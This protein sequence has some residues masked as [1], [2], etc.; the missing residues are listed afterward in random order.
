MQALSAPCSEGL[1]GF[2]DVIFRALALAALVASPARTASRGYWIQP[3]PEDP[4]ETALRDAL[5]L[6]GFSGP[7]E[8]ADALRRVADSRPGTAAAGLARLGAGYALLDAAQPQAALGQLGHP[9][10]AKTALSEY[11]LLA[12]GQAKEALRDAPGAAA[13]YLAAADARPN[14]PLACAALYKAAESF[15]RASELAS[16]VGTLGRALASCPGQEARTLF[17]IA[18]LQEQQNDRKAAAATLDRLDHEYPASPQALAIQRRLASLA[19]LLPAED[20]AARLAHDVRKALALFEANNCAAATPLLRRLKAR[21]LEPAD[22]DVVLVKLGR[23]DLAAKRYRDA[24]A[25]LASVT[26]ESAAG[27]EA[28]FYRARLALLKTAKPDQYEGVAVLFAGTP[29]GEEALFA[30]ANNF[31]KDARDAEALPYYRRLLEGFP[32]G[33]YLDRAGWRV[34]WGEF[35][36]GHF[37]EA[38][39]V[40]ERTAR[41]RPTSSF[42]AGLLYWAGRAQR[43]AGDAERARQLLEETVRRYK[44]GYHGIRAQAVL[45]QFAK[46][47][48]STI[49]ALVASDVDPRALIPEPQWSRIRQLLLIDRE[50]EA[51]EELRTL[52]TSPLVQA[53]LAWIEHQR[54]RLRPAITAMKR[55]YPEWVSESG[56]R[57]PREVWEILYPL[58]FGAL[59]RAKA[60]QESLEPALV[61]ALICQ[62]STFNAGAVSSAGARGM[63]QVMPYT[64]RALARALKIRYSTKA[65]YDPAVSLA[66][67]TRYLRQLFDR[68]GG[69]VE[70]V[71]AA[72]NAGPHRVDAWTAGRPDM[73]DEEFVESI[74]FSETRQYVMSVLANREQYRSLYDLDPA[75]TRAADAGSR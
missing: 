23:C 18:A 31:Q 21:K 5:T 62:E 14:G 72:Y 43:E 4:G 3:L 54:G 8:I 49:P 47:P 38:A 26:P 7:S 36:A 33:R 65:L 40:L 34:G 1:A 75:P 68:F 27:G 25:S 52:P 16:A 39:Q 67:G 46:R 32:D 64:G 15:E 45:A 22:R 71:L 69:S 73:G 51:Y 20:E 60:A 13:D 30:L 48:A 29:W 12:S 28:A 11:A 41:L 55:A 66:F 50:N 2:V 63:M 56:D 37:S 59:L 44:N 61:A 17:E 24:E 6:S 19:S 10:V 35:R 70:R 53:T 9:E 57:L 42:T 74:P 58:D